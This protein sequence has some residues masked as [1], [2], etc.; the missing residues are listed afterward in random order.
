[1]S[2]SLPLLPVLTQGNFLNAHRLYPAAIPRARVL[3]RHGDP[4]ARVGLASLAREEEVWVRLHRVSL[5]R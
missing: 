1:M 3:Q 2:M 5:S 4:T